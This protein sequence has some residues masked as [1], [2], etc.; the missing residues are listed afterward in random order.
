MWL[1]FLLSAIA[2]GLFVIFIRYFIT[3][4]IYLAK[5]AR[6]I[7]PTRYTPAEEPDDEHIQI[8][9]VGDIGRSPRMQYHGISVAQHGR[10]VDL[11]GYKGSFSPELEGLVCSCWVRDGEAP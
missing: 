8:L 10:H 2:G 1:P 6:D 4:A 11:V 5:K 3:F 7:I 9:V